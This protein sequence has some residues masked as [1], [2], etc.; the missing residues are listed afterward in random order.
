ML[1]RTR[2]L[3]RTRI[4][5]FYRLH[6]WTAA[7]QHRHLSSGLPDLPDSPPENA[8]AASNKLPDLTDPA[9][10]TDGDLKTVYVEDTE[11]LDTMKK[12]FSPEDDKF[13]KSI[14][15][16]KFKRADMYRLLKH[17]D[18]AKSYGYTHYKNSYVQA[19]NDVTEKDFPYMHHVQTES[20]VIDNN[21]DD[22]AGFRMAKT[23]QNRDL[24]KQELT[25]EEWAKQKLDPDV[26]AE[27]KE[28]IDEAAQ[29][30]VDD[31]K[32]E[33]RLNQ[34]RVPP[35]M[36]PAAY[37]E[38]IT[39][40]ND[41]RLDDLYPSVDAPYS[42][43]DWQHELRRNILLRSTGKKQLSEM[44]EK[45]L[46]QKH[47]KEKKKSVLSMAQTL[48]KYTNLGETVKP[49]K[50]YHQRM[51]RL[52][53]LH[54]ELGEPYQAPQGPLPSEVGAQLDQAVAGAL[55]WV[56]RDQSMA[57][58]APSGED[59]E[60]EADEEEDAK[61]ADEDGKHS[62]MLLEDEDLAT[63]NPWSDLGLEEDAEDAGAV[64]RRVDAER[65]AREARRQAAAKKKSD[66]ESL[67]KYHKIIDRIEIFKTRDTDFSNEVDVQNLFNEHHASAPDPHGIGDDI[68]QFHTDSDPDYDE[69]GN[70]IPPTKKI[71]KNPVGL[72]MLQLET[73]NEAR[74]PD[75]DLATLDTNYTHL[76]KFEEM[77]LN[78][79]DP[80]LEEIGKLSPI[81]DPIEAP[82]VFHVAQDVKEAMFRLNRAK[83]GQ[84]H[85]RELARMFGLSVIRTQAI[86]RLQWIESERVEK[87]GYNPHAVGVDADMENVHMVPLAQ[88]D[89]NCF[90][91]IN[92]NANAEYVDEGDLELLRRIEK[93]RN[94]KYWRKEERLALK[95]QAL[96][97]AGQLAYGSPAPT[98]KP[99][100]PLS[101]EKLNPARYDTVLTVLD[102]SKNG[103]FR[104]AVRDRNG[105]LR[106]PNEEEFKR[107]RLRE[108]GKYAYFNHVPFTYGEKP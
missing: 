47:E 23:R 41:P 79:L 31:T 19:D 18:D 64:Q 99:P 70:T 5:N 27:N 65:K 44:A 63:E 16:E 4:N 17:V 97:K 61:V 92:K 96:Y 37:R 59:E 10:M 39:N 49:L 106:E 87:Y 22:E 13:D 95:E 57:L 102:D 9:E 80:E 36:E 34:L 24:A 62:S 98:L 69:Q 76:D 82:R 11:T 35:I 32:E 28:A 88:W 2:V 56:E 85:S 91:N 90:E 3:N 105:N 78:N 26:Y 7:S 77:L 66:K 89:P 60:S 15:W 55:E 12:S 20:R 100:K 51:L 53:G 93:Q 104:V 8:P 42:Y 75:S 83:P 81:P 40:P 1:N 86:L 21:S 84:Y 108:K 54:Y 29:E 43:E 67:K 33:R 25:F 71:G 58:A 107:V 68:D 74:L 38:N 48:S 6:R 52:Y 94:D 14:Q 50:E 103:N 46:D 73:E 72:K 30:M 101:D 45:A